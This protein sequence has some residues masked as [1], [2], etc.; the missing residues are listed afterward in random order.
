[1]RRVLITALAT[2]AAAGLAISTPASASILDMSASASQGTLAHNANNQQQ[3]TTVTADL[4][5]NGPNIVNFDGHTTGDDELFLAGGNGQATIEGAEISAHNNALFYSADIY[6]T[7]HAGMSWIELALTGTNDNS[8]S[9]IDFYLTDSLTNTETMFHLLIGSGDTHYGF[10][11]DGGSSIT[12]LRFVTDPT[13][14]TV[15]LIKQVRI[16]A[17][18]GAIPEPSTW[19]MMLL[20]F[21]GIGMAVRRSKKRN[22]ALLQIA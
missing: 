10:G 1:M 8:P 3:G 20:G 2:A 11:V 17:A 18:P 4:G 16:I 14:T 22:P 21:A 7:G 6:L 5:S 9:Y 19:G 12:N 15:S 13:S